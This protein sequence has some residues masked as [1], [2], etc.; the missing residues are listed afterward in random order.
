MT[1][2][3]NG[4]ANAMLQFFGSRYLTVFFISMLPM[5]ET[6]GAIPIATTLGI[7]TF[8]AYLFSSMSAL[9]VCP[10]IIL[11][12]RPLINL[13]KKTSVFQRVGHF[14]EKNFRGKAESIDKKA[15][16]GN[17]SAGIR[18]KNFL[19][20]LALYAFVAVPL[21]MTG[22]WTGSAIAA[23]SK[24]KFRYSIPA[25]VLGNFTAAGIIALLD[26]LLGD[27]AYIILIV[28]AAFIVITVVTLLWKIMR[29]KAKR[30][31]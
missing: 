16:T 8:Q 6:R 22:V 18:K 25:I 24:M 17:E 23:F 2:F 19:H 4:I 15:E 21:P 29:S 27:K 1:E 26:F 31:S 14:L 20:A 12:L 7:P 11:C 30:E 9:V 3:I 28:L 13:L 10:I 5:V